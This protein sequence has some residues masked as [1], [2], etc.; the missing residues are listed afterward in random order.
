MQG[1]LRFLCH[2]SKLI[3]TDKIQGRDYWICQNGTQLPYRYR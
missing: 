1:A 2:K 3:M